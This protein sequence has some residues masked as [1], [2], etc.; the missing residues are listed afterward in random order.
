M[1]GIITG[2]LSA[3]PVAE[4]VEKKVTD[5]A[6]AAIFRSF[7]YMFCYKSLA[8]DFSSKIDDINNEEG[9][10]NIEVDKEKNNGKKIHAH[11]LKWL[12]DVKEI[13]KKSELSPSFKCIKYLPIPNPISRL[14]LGR[15]AVQK[16]KIVTELIDTSTKLFEKEIAYLPPPSEDVPTTNTVFQDFPSRQEAYIWKVL[17][18][19]RK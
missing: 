4:E 3:I 9:R 17:E 1:R 13:Q 5:L 14:R 2:L 18:P 12:E 10:M 11:V 7:K 6:V 19:A 16:S 8:E 15:N